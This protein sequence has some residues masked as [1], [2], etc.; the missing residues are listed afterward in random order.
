MAVPVTARGHCPPQADSS[1]S[2]LLLAKQALKE[3][4]QNS[5]G[6]YIAAIIFKTSF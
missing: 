1:K 5:G 3:N 4:N 6:Q 2:S